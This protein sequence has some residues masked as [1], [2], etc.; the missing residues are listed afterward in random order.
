VPFLFDDRPLARYRPRFLLDEEALNEPTGI[1]LAPA[2]PTLR[3]FLD[4]PSPAAEPVVPAPAT[5]GVPPPALPTFDLPRPQAPQYDTARA[6]TA[7]KVGLVAALAGLAGA[8]VTGRRNPFTAVAEGVAGGSQ[9]LLATMD[10]DYGERREAYLKGVENYN[11]ER[12]EHGRF[13]YGE[14]AETYRDAQEAERAAARQAVLDQRYRD[15]TLY[16]RGRD[17]VEDRRYRDELTYE[18]GRDRREDFEEDRDYRRGTYEDERDFR[19][20]REETLY[21]R[22]QATREEYRDLGGL[23]AEAQEAADARNRAVRQLERARENGTPEQVERAREAARKAEQRWRS[24]NQA[25]EGG[26]TADTPSARP[27]DDMAALARDLGVTVTSTTGGS[28]VPGSLHP[29]GRAIDVRT[30]DL[31]EQQV[32][33]TIRAY[34]ARGYVVR[35]ERRDPG[36]GRWTGPHLHIEAPAGTAPAPAEV[37]V[38]PAT[39]RPPSG[40][41]VA[42]FSRAFHRLVAQEGRDINVVL[43]TLDRAVQSGQ[44]TQAEADAVEGYL[45]DMAP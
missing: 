11:E 24:A 31:S 45:L 17:R 43:T 34:Q 21:E 39:P 13:V 5:G 26:R 2:G 44:M 41:R 32:Q 38:S 18:R 8:L 3:A 14:Q 20:G 37:P 27:A 16:E 29:Q 36:H 40:E 22:G 15:E 12:A 7:R 25:Y 10:E 42:A 1:G 35:D 23:R 19:A 4:A 30:R 28:H 33:D 6:E 9:N